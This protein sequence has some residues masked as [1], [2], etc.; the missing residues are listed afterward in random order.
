MVFP[1]G[2]WGVVDSVELVR[3]LCLAVDVQGYGGLDDRAQSRVQEELLELL[4]AAASGAGIDRHLWIRQAQG[5]GELSLIPSEESQPRI[6]DEFVGELAMRV[7]RR[8]SQRSNRQRL[9]LRVALDYGPVQ[10]AANGFSGRCVVVVSRL[11]NARP[12]KQALACAPDAGLAMILSSRVYTDLVL[13][14]HTCLDPEM[15]RRV[16]VREKEYAEDAWLW[17]PG[18]DVH[19]LS[20]HDEHPHRPDADAAP[21]SP[22][23]AAGASLPPPAPLSTGAASSVANVFHGQVNA[24]GATFGVRNG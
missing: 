12:A 7:Y 10:V 8:N 23:S 14:G 6:L 2:V 5:D 19:Q 1:I 13:S 24:R 4:D 22:P 9:R 15:F 21:S 17:V 3:R 11:V 18:T 20:I 16:A